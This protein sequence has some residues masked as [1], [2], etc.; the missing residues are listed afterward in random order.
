MD[1][2]KERDVMHDYVR[3]GTDPSADRPIPRESGSDRVVPK[4]HVW[5][6]VISSS[7]YGS[8]LP[9]K[10]GECPST[11]SCRSTSSRDDVASWLQ[12]E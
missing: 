8:S 11:D 2:N 10:D 12:H 6:I 1:E 3:D 5:C 4:G 7:S 9:C